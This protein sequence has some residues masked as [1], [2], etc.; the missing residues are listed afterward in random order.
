MKQVLMLTTGGTIASKPAA[1]GLEP[2]LTGQELLRYLGDAAGEYHIDVQE[3]L[4]LYNS[5]E[6]IL[7][8]SDRIFE[9]S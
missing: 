1:A 5:A 8:D 4:D 9:I 2:Q 3:L 7:R 6:T